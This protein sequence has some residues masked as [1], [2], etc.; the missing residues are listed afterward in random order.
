ML[1]FVIYRMQFTQ[2]TTRSGEVIRKV[3]VIQ[4]QRMLV[5]GRP[6]LA[7]STLVRPPLNIF[8]F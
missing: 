2:R 8:T 6:D 7:S 4:H 3:N 1:S 5:N